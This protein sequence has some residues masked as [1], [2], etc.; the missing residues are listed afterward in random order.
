M[1]ASVLLTNTCWKHIPF[2]VWTTFSLETGPV[3]QIDLLTRSIEV[4]PAYD[5]AIMAVDLVHRLAMWRPATG[6]P[7]RRQYPV[8]G[9]PLVP[10]QGNLESCLDLC[11]PTYP[12]DYVSLNNHTLASWFFLFGHSSPSDVQSLGPSERAGPCIAKQTSFGFPTNFQPWETNIGSG[13]E[14][15]S[16]SFQKMHFKQKE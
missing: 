11:K 15:S 1:F 12:K 4:F 8:A 14:E 9:V 16:M 2:C 3:P 5:A 10:V 6:L 7:P 13:M